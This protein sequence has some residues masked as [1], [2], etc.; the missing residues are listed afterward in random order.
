LGIRDPKQ[1]ILH[2][3]SA[4]YVY[5]QME[6][7]VKFSRAEEAVASAILDMEMKK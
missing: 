6:H 4:I 1:F 3:R 7:D 5:K 2:V